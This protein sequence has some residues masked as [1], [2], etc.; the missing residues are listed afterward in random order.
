MHSKEPQLLDLDQTY[1]CPACKQGMLV[2]IT[3]T[4][5]WGCDRCKQIFELQAEPNTVGK[6]TAPA[7]RRRI[8]RWDG[9]RWVLKPTPVKPLLLVGYVWVLGPLVLG[10]GW[11]GWRLLSAIQFPRLGRIALILMALV[12]MF[13]VVLRR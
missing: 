12:V 2:P 5:A 7:S 10:I 3:L 11:M 4:E 13:W 9:K 8:W 1:P 6:L